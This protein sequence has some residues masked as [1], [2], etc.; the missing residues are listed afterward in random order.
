MDRTRFRNKNTYSPSMQT[1][2]LHCSTRIMVDN[3]TPEFN[4]SAAW[5]EYDIGTTTKLT[6]TT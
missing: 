5:Q 6:L 4:I 1:E 3:A 2:K